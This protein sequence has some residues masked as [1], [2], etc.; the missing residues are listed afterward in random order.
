MPGFERQDVRLREIDD[1]DVIANAGAVGRR[2]IGAVN[3]ALRR[4]AE[5]DFEHVR[6]QMRFDAMMF[7]KFLARAGGVEITERDEFQSVNL[8]IPFEHL[9][10]TSTSI[11]RKD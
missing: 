1:V 2:I 11:R 8:V 10:R 7:A 6:D 5:R 3:F 9:S 4:L